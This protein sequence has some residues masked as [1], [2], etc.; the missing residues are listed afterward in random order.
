MFMWIYL[1]D[2]DGLSVYV[3]CTVIVFFFIHCYM[4]FRYTMWYVSGLWPFVANKSLI[5]HVT[6]TVHAC[7]LRSVS[8]HA[9]QPTVS[10]NAVPRNSDTTARQK[11]RCLTSSWLRPILQSPSPDL[12]LTVESTTTAAVQRQYQCR[13]ASRYSSQANRLNNC[14][15]PIT[16]QR[17]AVRLSHGHRLRFFFLQA[18]LIQSETRSLGR[19]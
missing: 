14:C 8:D 12:F 4:F 19:D 9:P 17:P 18:G 10:R 2:I 1:H 15:K 7:S 16:R 3:T 5:Y 6:L 13:G 11:L